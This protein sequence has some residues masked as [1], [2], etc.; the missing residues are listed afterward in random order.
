M[1]AN[2]WLSSEDGLQE[3]DEV[4][5]YQAHRGYPVHVAEDAASQTRLRML[6]RDECLPVGY[7]VRQL[8]LGT[9]SVLKDQA[10]HFRFVLDLPTWHANG[11]TGMPFESPDACVERLSVVQ[12][13][14]AYGGPCLAYYAGLRM[15]G[16]DG[17]Q[18]G[19]AMGY[20]NPKWAKKMN[21]KVAACL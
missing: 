17:E 10:R 1:S 13:L 3:Y 15:D 4:V 14:E 9:V 6:F 11:A 5:A 2:D 8:R 16:L 20:R 21:D 7:H 19:L 18:A 12:R